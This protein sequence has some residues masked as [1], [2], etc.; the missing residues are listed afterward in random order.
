MQ[1]HLFR[2]L[3]FEFCPFQADSVPQLLLIMEGISAQGHW[4]SGVLYEK[5]NGFYFHANQWR[6][7]LQM[8]EVVKHL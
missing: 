1:P 7:V 4:D 6:P 5:H 2:F 8:C 3:T